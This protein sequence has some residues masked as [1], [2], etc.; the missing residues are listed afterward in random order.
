VS[1]PVVL[2]ENSPHWA[3]LFVTEIQLIQAS[4]GQNVVATH[5]IGSTSIPAILA[6]PVIDILIELASLEEMDAATGKMETLGYE[7]MGEF[8]IEG[9]RFFRKFNSEG[10]RTHHIHAYLQGDDHIK[11]HLAFRDF[12]IAHPVKARE[13]SELKARLISMPSIS[14]QA[15]MDGKAPFIQATEAQAI[16]WYASKNKS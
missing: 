12:L 8:G 7:V 13:Y 2:E 5:H 6:K 11:R 16:E 9:R 15:Y 4:L 3:D 1:D 10:I 14:R